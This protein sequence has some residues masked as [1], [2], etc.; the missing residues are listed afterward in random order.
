MHTHLLLILTFVFGTSNFFAQQAFSISGQLKDAETKEKISYGR[1]VVLNQK[2]S[3]ITGGL[4]DEDGFYQFQLN[5]GYYKISFP[6]L[7]YQSD[8]LDVG[9]IYQETFL[10][11]T[12]LQKGDKELDEF[13]VNVAGTRNDFNKDVHVVTDKLKNGSNDTKDVLDKISGLNYDRYEGT[14]SVDNDK[15][16]II[17]VNGV[18]KN[19][20]YIKNLAP[21]RLLRVEVIRD[22]GGRYGVEGYSAIVNIILRND[23]KGSEFFFKANPLFDL[24]TKDIN[25]L[26]ITN[27][28][29]LSYNYTYNKVNL[30][31]IANQGYNYFPITISNDTRF[32][33]SLRIEERPISDRNNSVISMLN[34]NYTVGVDYN[35]S[36]TQTLSLE[37]SLTALPRGFDK[38]SFDYST[39]LF[40]NDSL[41]DEYDFLTTTDSRRLVSYSSLFYVRKFRQNDELNVN[42]TYSHFNQDAETNTI[43][44][45]IYNRLET[46][47]NI[48]NNTRFNAEYSR[49]IN[50]TW[51]L[52]IGYGNSYKGLNNQF[53]VTQTILSDSSQFQL[54]NNFAFN[55]FRHKAYS[56]A[57]WRRNA[58]LGVKFGLA[59]ELSQPE[60]EGTRFTY[61]IY[62]PLVDIAYSP[63]KNFNASL[64]LRTDSRYPNISEVNPFQSQVNPFAFSTGDPTIKPTTIQRLSLRMNLLQG[65]A[66]LEPYYHFS[67]NYI[68]QTGEIRTDGLFQYQAGNVD[69]YENRGLKANLTIPFGK[70]LFLQNDFNFYTS[71]IRDNSTSIE[72]SDWSANSK[73]LYVVD[74]TNTV[75]GLI[76]QKENVKRINGLGYSR[77]NVDFWLAFVQKPIFKQRGSIMLGYFLPVNFGMNYN[78]GSYQESG[79]YSVDNFVDVELI[80]N[81]FIVEFNFRFNKGKKVKK[82][83]K[84]VQMES[85]GGGGGIF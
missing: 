12:Q 73:L 54:E 24:D 70:Q 59:T 14:I 30:Y 46:G 67:N 25:D 4:T 22:P 55:D 16:I 81:M 35:I 17:L 61:L 48:K 3:V 36:P 69:F 71:K 60:S 38:N 37:S 26:L 1:V 53:D 10:G 78:Q 84:D 85:E 29:Y 15:N 76:Y 75:L 13:K 57:S 32:G 6:V 33:D 65:L 47:K 27:Q 39:Q 34:T 18:E 51:N 80:K 82:K 56:Y 20:D 58:K 77:G 31:G 11:V 44:S 45:G 7:G 41:V 2:D 28:F 64:K 43:Q 72:V 52:Q 5:P 9:V 40:Y 83:D 21:D 62:Q 42:F 74:S 63:S 66:S 19:Y 68:A 50:P 79:A 49:E 23:Y 8:T